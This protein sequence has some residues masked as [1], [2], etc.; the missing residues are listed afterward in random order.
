MGSTSLKVDDGTKM[1]GLPPKYQV[2]I[3]EGSPYPEFGTV[4]MKVTN[5]ISLTTQTTKPHLKG[6]LVEVSN[7]GLACCTP[8]CMGYS[9]GQSDGCGGLCKSCMASGYMCQLDADKWQCDP[10]ACTP[11]CGP[12]YVCSAGSCN[13]LC[14]PDNSL[15]CGGICCQPG[16]TCQGGVCNG[17]PG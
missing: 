17:G 14:P 6:D 2:E 7:G 3:G 5:T 13:P 16:Q 9:C 8:N 11:P 10:M 15:L 4:S 1:P 12:G